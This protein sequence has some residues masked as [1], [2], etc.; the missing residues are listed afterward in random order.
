MDFSLKY[1][2]ARG[3]KYLPQID[4]QVKSWRRPTGPGES[5]AYPMKARHFQQLAGAFEIPRFL[6]LVV[7]PADVRAYTQADDECLRLHRACYWASFADVEPPWQL[8]GDT[9][10]KVEVLKKNLLTAE[11][12]LGLILRPGAAL[13]VP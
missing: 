6:L 7:V 8:P 2:G 13:E 5:W 4:V 11:A 9:T 1:P 3:T 12:L 10:V